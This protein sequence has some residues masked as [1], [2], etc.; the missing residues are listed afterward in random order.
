MLFG[1]PIVSTAYENGP[2]ELPEGKRDAIMVAT[3]DHLALADALL[4]LISNHADADKLA[5]AAGEKA[6][7]FSRERILRGRDALLC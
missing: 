1:L 3:N 4:G 6:R 7:L 2:C 5:P